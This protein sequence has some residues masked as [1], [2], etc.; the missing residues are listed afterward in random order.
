MK[1]PFWA[2]TLT[3]LG[4]MFLCGL[5]YWQL[6]RLEW[7]TE[8]L[9]ALDAA[10]QKS[11]APT[12]FYE[13][14][15]NLAKTADDTALIRY[16]FLEGRWLHDKEIAVGPRTWKGKPGYHILTPMALKGGGTALVNRGWV[17]IDKKL[18][19][20][21]PESLPGP[22]KGMAMGL[23]RRPGKPSYFTPANNPQKDEWYFIDLQQMA[24]A[25]DLKK[26]APLVLYARL[27]RNKADLPVKEALEWRPNNNHRAYA[28]FWFT[29]AAALAVIYCLRFLKR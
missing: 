27:D 1:L 19:A 20:Q 23:L 14:I 29:L 21:R 4:I 6:Q 7:K 18:A 3:V 5:G 8:L 2:T 9:A 26:L 25:R 10:K 15:N 22:K 28:I 13:Q 16:V 17:P 24:E 12:L 11:A